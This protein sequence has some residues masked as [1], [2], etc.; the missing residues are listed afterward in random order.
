M[1]LGM[2]KVSQKSTVG[3]IFQRS[4]NVDFK[5]TKNL[6][7]PTV[8]KNAYLSSRTEFHIEIF[9]FFTKYLLLKMLKDSS[10]NIKVDFSALGECMT[11]I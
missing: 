2:M 4:V 10:V 8:F 11:I 1:T 3:L 5:Q 9:R 7:D 6:Y